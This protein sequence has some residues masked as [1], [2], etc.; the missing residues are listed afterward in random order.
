MVQPSNTNT[1][2]EVAYISASDHATDPDHLTCSVKR[3]AKIL[4][5]GQTKAWALI[6]EGEVDVIRLGGRTLVVC[7]SIQRMIQRKLASRQESA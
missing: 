1:S 3:F 7:D 6:K 5:I 4:D 2:V